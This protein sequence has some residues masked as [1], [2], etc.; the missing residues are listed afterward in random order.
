MGVQGS[1]FRVEGSGFRVEGSGFRV[2]GSGFRV[3]GVVQ[4]LGIT[5]P[6]STVLPNESITAQP[7]SQPGITSLLLYYSRA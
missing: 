5:P 3:E 1:W 7:S 2:E 4:S 6:S